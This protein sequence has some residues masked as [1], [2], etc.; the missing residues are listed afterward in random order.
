MD[1]QGVYALLLHVPNFSV[2][3]FVIV[4]RIAY[5]YTIQIAMIQSFRHK[6][7]ER[8]WTKGDTKLLPQTQIKK[9][10]RILDAIDLLNDVPRDLEPFRTWRPHLLHGEYKGYWSLDVIGNY[11][12]IFQFE[13]GHAYNLSYLDTH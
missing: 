12:I 10:R 7:L 1:L 9:I 2:L 3:I 6:G 11:R 13:N 8:F 5:L 4:I